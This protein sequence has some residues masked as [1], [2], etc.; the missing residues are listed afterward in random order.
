[1][2]LV[3]VAFPAVTTIYMGMFMSVL[4]FQFYDFGK[5]YDKWL[6]LDP[7]SVGNNP[8]NNQFNLMGYNALYMIKN[9]G[10][11]CLTIFIGPIAFVLF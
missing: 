7:D 4:T 10:T 8:L 1:M 5:Y 9:F 3:N 2:V 11:L 6:N